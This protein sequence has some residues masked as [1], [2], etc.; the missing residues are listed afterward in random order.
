M[1]TTDYTLTS[2]FAVPMVIAHHP[3]PGAMNDAL[4]RLFM[5]RAESGAR[6]ANPQ[7]LVERNA[8]LYESNFTL[9]DWPDPELK[10]LR[11]WCM[12]M[13]YRTVGQLG[14]YGTDDLQRLHVAVESWFHITRSGGYFAVHNHALHSWSGVYCVDPGAASAAHP[15]SGRLV[16]LNPHSAGAMYLDMANARMSP[17]YDFGP[18]KL[19]LEPGQLVLFPSWLLHHVNPYFGERERITVAFNARFRMVG[20]EPGKVPL[21]RPHPG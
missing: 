3:A 7:P 14:Q 12:A 21:T 13:L 19:Q 2:A 10:P 11:D 9:F 5:A 1:T 6:F 17:P 16:F 8:S 20:V 18:R 15:E 4:R